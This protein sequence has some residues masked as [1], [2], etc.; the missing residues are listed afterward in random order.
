[1]KRLL[2]CLVPLTLL[3][4]SCGRSWSDD[5]QLAAA[6]QLCARILPKQCNNIDFVLEE[7][8]GD[9][10]S[11]ETV[12]GR[13]KIGGNNANSLSRGFGDYLRDYCKTGVTWWARD[14][15][16]EPSQL[17]VI[18]S[19]I[20][21]RS[22]VG[23]RFFLNYCTYGYSLAWWKWKDWERL[24]DWMA[25]HG[26]TLALANTGQEKVWL[27]TWQ[28]FGLS[29]QQIRE[30]F[31]G[32]AFLPWHRMTNID[33]WQGPLPQKWIDEQAELQK[34]IIGRELSLGIS[35]ILGSFTGH[36]PEALKE[37]Y[38]E[39]N[40][41]RLGK[42]SSFKEDYS[43]WYLS[44]TDTLFRSIQRAYLR[45][46]QKL[47]GSAS[48]IYGVDLF[49]EVNPPSWEP[50][51]LSEAAK[52][53]YEAISE[54]DPDA[55]WLQMSWLFWH[56]RQKWTPERI[57]AYITPV[58]KGRLVMLDYYCDLVEVYKQ[59]ENFYGQDFIWSYLGNF[60]GNTMIAGN[61]QE[62]GRKIDSVYV[63]APSECV[64]LGC[65][66]E[67]LDVNPVMYE[68]VLDRAWERT[69]D[70]YSW[71]D[72]FADR[73]AGRE[74]P[75]VR[76]AW[77]LMYDKVQKQT[78][79]HWVS[80][81]PAR[82]SIDGKAQWCRPVLTYDNND[83]FDA[84]G[85]LLQ[86]GECDTPD[87]RFDC[88]N[89][90]R[91]CLD[92]YFT[93]LYEGLLSDYEKGDLDGVSGKGKLMMDILRD[94]N[95]LT[96]ADSYFLLGKWIADARSWGSSPAEKDFYETNARLLLSCW[97]H[98]GI[99][100]TDY[101]NRDWN[102][103]ISTYYQP[104]WEKFIGMLEESLITGENF[105][106]EAFLEWCKD[107]EWNWAHSFSILPSAPSGDAR[108]LS[109]ALYKKYRNI[110]AAAQFHEKKENY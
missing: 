4:V 109:S 53:T 8:D 100:L 20:V 45:N 91:Q 48:H 35:P 43:A 97:G 72:S 106:N 96:A 73:H 17:P 5:P 66:L 11:L 14:R 36:V 85:E 75:H 22:L 46:Q 78:G 84:W 103:L 31:T 79:G 29:P 95:T 55:V 59:T 110:S 81:I 44:P 90:A 24:I 80:K 76:S 42:W 3:F 50:E 94:V 93:S 83:L 6:E 15:V 65:T 49:N 89:F 10:Y 77:R 63:A 33:S 54:T 98:R 30:Y 47:F 13:L 102:G 57:E 99:I 41:S 82:P 28:E 87:Y 69:G 51:Y 37:I 62:V 39:A 1:M 101:A 58:P 70:D 104:R 27:E 86:A 52:G 25:L 92:N 61:L 71:I 105:D 32:P 2:A 56:K 108:T 7:G 38:P 68:Y 9:F 26:V 16:K 67:G 107:Y 12:D 21:R 34:K 60:G 88:V 74:D 19:R 18:E 23:K 40:I 64:G